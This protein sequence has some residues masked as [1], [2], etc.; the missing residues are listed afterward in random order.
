MLLPFV[1]VSRGSMLT[2][3]A[4]RFGS[5]LQLRGF[6]TISQVDKE[7]ES[8]SIFSQISKSRLQKST[9]D[10][11]AD[12]IMTLSL[13][14]ISEL[15]RALNDPEIWRKV[16]TTNTFP[17][18]E[19]IPLGKNRSPFPHPKHLFSGIDADQRPGMHVVPQK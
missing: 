5:L 1:H 8:F 12:E 11:I 17:Q 18:Q 15:S 3:A 6:A 16:G 2:A 10:E 7:R 13:S 14:E 19:T 9:V 4:R